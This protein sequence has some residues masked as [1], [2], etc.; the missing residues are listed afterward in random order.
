MKAGGFIVALLLLAG[1][2]TAQ[3]PGDSLFQ[4][5]RTFYE[6]GQTEQA[7]AELQRCM[8]LYPEKT[9]TELAVRM[10]YG[11]DDDMTD[12]D[13]RGNALWLALR[14]PLHN[15]TLSPTDPRLL[16]LLE[17]YRFLLIYNQVRERQATLLALNGDTTR[18][19]AIL[20]SVVAEER[21]SKTRDHIG[22]FACLQLVDLLLATAEY[23]SAIHYAQLT[24][25]ELRPQ[26]VCGHVNWDFRR[27]ERCMG[28]AYAG[29]GL[30]DS[31]IK[32]LLPIAFDDYP[33][34]KS[35]PTLAIDTLI[36]LLQRLD[37]TPLLTQL[38]RAIELMDG[39][40]AIPNAH[41]PQGGY[42]D[43]KIQLCGYAMLAYRS[44]DTNEHFGQFWKT[45][46]PKA[47]MQH[48]LRRSPLYRRL[49]GVPTDE[50]YDWD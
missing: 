20:K 47:E 19:V 26:M 21:Q 48:Y 25:T 15:E 28:V 2:L 10:R 36:A 33:Y 11:C 34:S 12:G 32:Y 7:C 22:N 29:L 37:S 31:A 42:L 44:L 17:N 40:Q 8:V 27:R 46:M 3:T 41:A 5:A 45:P 39:R 1:C 24:K 43:C 6:A 30:R 14:E 35:N 4:R 49:S 18:A 13:R 50:V 9:R 38:D 23:D 16:D